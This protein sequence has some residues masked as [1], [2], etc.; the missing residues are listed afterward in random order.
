MHA[1]RSMVTAIFNGKICILLFNLKT[2]TI[3]VPLH[4]CWER[5]GCGK[6]SFKEWNAYD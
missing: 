6:M 3:Y 2:S 4:I 1:N 5:D